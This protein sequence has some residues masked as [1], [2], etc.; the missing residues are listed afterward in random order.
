MSAAASEELEG[1][2][3]RCSSSDWRERSAA[4]SE[5]SDFGSRERGAVLSQCARLSS[6]LSSRLRDANNRV[7]LSAV[8]AAGAFTQLLRGESALD[9]AAPLL[10]PGLCGCLIS[11]QR[12]VSEGSNAVLDRLLSSADPAAILQPLVAQLRAT[13]SSRLRACM[14]EKLAGLLPAAHAR[15]PAAVLRHALPAVFA[16][17]EDSKPDVKTGAVDV[18]LRAAAAIGVPAVMDAARTSLAE[19]QLDKVKRALMGRR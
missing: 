19:A 13:S 5:L 11:A 7:A 14:L 18:L 8:H 10:L 4:L 6:E 9:R 16:L 15:R 2:L 3:G 1:L 17:M 12:P